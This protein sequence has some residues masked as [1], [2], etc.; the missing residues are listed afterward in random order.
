MRLVRLLGEQDVERF[1]LK[2]RAGF[3][4][5]RGQTERDNCSLWEGCLPESDVPLYG[6]ELPLVSPCSE[7]S[8]QGVA[9]DALL[10]RAAQF[11]LADAKRYAS[12]RILK[13]DGSGA[14]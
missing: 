9:D 6:I 8:F 5:L 7:S 1:S 13:R 12:E 10:W 14:P 4:R 11:A 2:K 3:L